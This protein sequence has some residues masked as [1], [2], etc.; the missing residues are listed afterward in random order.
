M[1]DLEPE[2][3]SSTASRCHADE[4][5][6]PQATGRRLKV[7]MLTV[8]LGVG[9]TETQIRD[10]ATNLDRERFWCLVCALKGDGEVAKQIEERGI[11]VQV[12]GGKGF[13]DP[14]L[15]WRLIRL[16][17]AFRPDVIHAFLPP[18]N[19]AGGLVSALCRVPCLI[20]SCRDLGVSKRWHYVVAERMVAGLADVVTCCSDAVRRSVGSRFGGDSRRYLT[21]HNGVS[22]ERFQAQMPLDAASIG[23]QGDGPLI[24]TVCRLEE[25]TKGLSV[26]LNAM[27]LLKKSSGNLPFRLLV[28]GDGPARAD[29]QQLCIQLGLAQEVAF[30]GGRQDVDRIL[31]M[32]SLFVLPSLSEG[33]GIAIVEAMAAGLPVVASAVGGIPEIVLHGK[34][35]LLVP[36][37][38][39]AALAQAVDQ[40]MSDPQLRRSFGLKG[41]EIAR[42]RFSLQAAVRRHEELY[43]RYAARGAESG[44]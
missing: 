43:A 11:Q 12:L 24:G 16:V 33:F 8:G 20:L 36:P 25:P 44:A 38:N 9:G 32:L 18:A 30:S 26:L 15:L 31:P 29:L 4:V 7:M 5:I 3:A 19:V 41:R 21:I 13:L 28:V 40:C 10:L 39:A 14:R 2:V 17:R 37:G 1:I 35:G 34:T 42:E 23:L 22:I 6:G 27:A